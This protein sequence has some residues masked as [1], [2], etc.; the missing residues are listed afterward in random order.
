S[1]SLKA[2]LQGG[3][4]LGRTGAWLKDRRARDDGVAGE[5]SVS[6]NVKRTSPDG[7]LEGVRIF[8]FDTASRLVT[9]V[10]ARNARIGNGFWELDD[11]QVTHWP[12]DATQA[13]REEQ[14]AH[15]RWPSALDAGV[16]AAAVLPVS[17]MSTLE[18]WRYSRH[19]AAQE[20]AA[21]RHSI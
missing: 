9:R 7:V 12:S 20:Q 19:L 6:V 5:L 8:E 11:A 15:L 4:E 10:S 21:Q 13:V 2:G 3:R 1:V 18:L 17:T 16:V 14:H